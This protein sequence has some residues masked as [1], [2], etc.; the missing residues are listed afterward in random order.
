MFLKTVHPRLAG[1]QVG[2]YLILEITPPS[3]A[4]Q[5]RTA[6]QSLDVL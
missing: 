3:L 2:Y 4:G 5:L 6:R 1:D